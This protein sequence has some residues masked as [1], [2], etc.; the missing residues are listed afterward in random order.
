MIVWISGPTGA[1]KSTLA[2][3]FCELGYSLVEEQIPADVYNAFSAD[4]ARY[5]FPL[6]EAI[7]QSRYEA[8]R[9]LAKGSHVVF[10]RSIDEDAKVFCR[11]HH[12]LGL[13]DDYQ[14][15]QLLQ[16]SLKLQSAMS[17]PDVIIFVCAP[18]V[19]L[20]KR[21]I[22]ATHAPIIVDNLERQLSLYTD[23]LTTR[24]ED[25]LRIDNSACRSAIT[26]QLFQ[27]GRQC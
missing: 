5:C 17:V 8:C 19:V 16:F 27:R 9:A 25:I 22:G 1:G 23:W 18:L 2:N 7:M 24:R 4:P 10:D 6:Q 26:Q 15:G 3:S 11:M 13:I 20:R 12:E 14:Y 21:V